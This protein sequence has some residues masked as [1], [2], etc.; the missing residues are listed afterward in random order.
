MRTAEAL[1]RDQFDPKEWPLI[2]TLLKTAYRAADETIRDNPILQVTS[3]KD[4]R[5]RLVQWSVDL[6]IER[7]IQN[8]SLSCDYAWSYYAKPTGRYLQL[9]FS[10]ST[11]SISQVQCAFRQPRSVVFRENA[12]LRTQPVFEGFDDGAEIDGLP[13]FLIIHGHQDLT[14]AH[15]AMP[16]ADSKV[17][18]EYRSPNLLRLPHAIE[19]DSSAAP[20]EN[21]D[22]DAEGLAT[23]KDEIEKWRRD[24]DDE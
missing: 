16:S 22:F 12:R 10:H 6:A 21:T 5:G 8:G 19:P 14:F 1:I 2:P 17:D 9:Q 4:N 13:H 24:H 20:T 11:A 3:A 23:L 18:Y 15:I 7:A